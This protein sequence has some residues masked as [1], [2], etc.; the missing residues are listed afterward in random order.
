MFIRGRKYLSVSG[1]NAV[2][3]GKENGSKFSC[4]DPALL[5]QFADDYES[6]DTDIAKKI[7][8]I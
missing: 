8:G 1:K 3:D 5:R 4:P 7:K 2:A 6:M